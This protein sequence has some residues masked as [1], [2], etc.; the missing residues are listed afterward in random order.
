M[1]LCCSLCGRLEAL[2]IPPGA[3]VNGRAGCAHG[4]RFVET[5]Y[6]AGWGRGLPDDSRR[7]VCLQG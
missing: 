4:V 6:G 2:V 5:A 7:D 1:A 3:A